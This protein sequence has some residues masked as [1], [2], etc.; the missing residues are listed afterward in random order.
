MKLFPF[1]GM[2]K[3]NT[4]DVLSP[5]IYDADLGSDKGPNNSYGWGQLIVFKEEPY[6]TQ[7]YIGNTRN[8]L[9]IRS[10]FEN[11]ISN[12]FWQQIATE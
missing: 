10:I 4:L 2:G 12:A 7:F 9:Y 8:C 5:G 1:M 6:I 3:I 11:N